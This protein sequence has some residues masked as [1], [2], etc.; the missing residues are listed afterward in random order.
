QVEAMT[1]GSRIVVMKDGIVQQVDTP[2]KIYL[3]PANMFVAGFMGSPPINF[4]EGKLLESPE[5]LLEFH[6][7]QYALAIPASQS[8]RLIEKRKVNRVVTIG[9]RS[10]HV[11]LDPAYRD[12]HPRSQIPGSHKISEFMG[13]DLFLYADIGASNLFIARADLDQSYDDNEKVTLTL[14]LRKAL[15]FDTDTGENLMQ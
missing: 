11:H 13:A 5:G 6:T 1:M 12:A 15:Y 10:E 4:I 7:K 9:I 14:D 3:N 2:Q 8:N